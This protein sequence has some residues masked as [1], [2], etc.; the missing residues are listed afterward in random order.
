MAKKNNSKT[1]KDFK[2]KHNTYL[3]KIS[4]LGTTK[5]SNKK[6]HEQ[7]KIKQQQNN[8]LSNPMKHQQKGTTITTSSDMLSSATISKKKKI[9]TYYILSFLFLVFLIVFILSIRNI[10]IWQKNNVETKKQ[11]QEQVSETKISETVDTEKTEVIEQKKEIPKENPYW[12]YIKMKLIQ[13]DFSNLKS[14]NKETIGWIQVNGTNINYPFVQTTNNSFYLNHSFNKTS[15]EAGWVFMDYRNNP[16]NFD[17]NTILYAH[18]RI[19]N[20][21]F[22]SLKKILQSKWLDNTNNYIIKLSTESENTLWQVFSVYK[23]PTT[24]DYLS[25]HFSNQNS[26]FNFASLLLNRSQFDFKTIIN[27][28]DKILTL[29]TC[30]DDHEKVV[31]HAKLIKKEKRNM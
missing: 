22:G 1:L 9:V 18:G 19:D 3:T 26:F 2:R 24:T 28:N 10:I 12:D 21:M 14:K 29:S 17:Q 5:P 6:K 20:T 15:N 13:V 25:I 11:I 16:T 23:I 27:E 8:S 7:K 31:L 30:Y 4:K